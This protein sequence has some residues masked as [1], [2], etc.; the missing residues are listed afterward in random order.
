MHSSLHQVSAS[1]PANWK[2]ENNDWA[3]KMPFAGASNPTK[4]KSPRTGRSCEWSTRSSTLVSRRTSGCAERD[5]PIGDLFKSSSN[6]IFFC[7]KSIYTRVKLILR[8]NFQICN[9]FKANI[10]QL[11]RRSQAG[12]WNHHAAGQHGQGAVPVRK[13]QSFC[14]SSRIG[15][16]VFKS[17][18]F[19]HFLV[20]FCVFS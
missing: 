5:M 12:H 3:T 17:V 6:G 13:D 14:Q 9:S 16:F 4:P 18:E 7:L 1:V 15:L 10:S 19:C 2:M 20:S 8:V 11:E